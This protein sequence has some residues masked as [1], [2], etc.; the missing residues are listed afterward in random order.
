MLNEMSQD[1]RF[2]PSSYFQVTEYILTYFPL[3]FHAD[4]Q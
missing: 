4:N 1:I 3:P 2:F